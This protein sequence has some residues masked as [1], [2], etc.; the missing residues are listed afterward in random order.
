VSLEDEIELFLRQRSAGVPRIL[1]AKF[2][3]LSP[4]ALGEISDAEFLR[5]FQIQIKALNEAVIRLAKAID[6]LSK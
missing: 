2:E 4:E 3:E 6:E 1:R 5:G